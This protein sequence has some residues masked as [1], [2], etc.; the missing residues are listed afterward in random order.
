MSATVTGAPASA[1]AELRRGSTAVRVALGPGAPITAFVHDG[2]DWC[3]DGSWQDHAP[4]RRACALPTFVAG[5]A[6]AHFPDGG[7]LATDEPIVEVRADER[8]NMITVTWPASS[9]PLVWTRTLAL[10]A[11]G[12]LSV[13]YTVS[14]RQRAPLPFVWGMPL[15]M[16][17]SE[18]LAID[19]P[20]GARARVAESWGDGLAPQG[21]EFAWPTLRDGGHLVDL[22]RPSLLGPGRAVLCY[23]E[24]PRG[25]FSVRTPSGILDVRSDPGAV[26]HAR[27]WIN[28][29]VD[30]P[31]SPPRRWWQRR[32]AVP[33]LAVGPAVGAPDLLS[34]AV[35]AWGA[36]RWVEPG[37]TLS[38]SIS[39]R[40]LPLEE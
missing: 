8:G 3:R 31:G 4:T 18:G 34:E 16:P 2:N 25:R 15:A 9:Y 29:G 5:A 17:W 23:V 12:A 38:W 39:I 24:L 36:A 7:T 40:V 32:T 1:G 28:N 11:N 22:A 26:T 19:L 10:E 33:S 37:E 13:R 21:S 35:G 30:A 27:I 20:R 6:G 14:N